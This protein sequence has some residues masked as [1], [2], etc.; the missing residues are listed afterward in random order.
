MISRSR[1]DSLG[2]VVAEFF[3]DPQK[4]TQFSGGGSRNFLLSSVAK[5]YFYP[6]F[7]DIRG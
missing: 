6:T 3:R 7:N 1:R 5:S 4:P 2:G